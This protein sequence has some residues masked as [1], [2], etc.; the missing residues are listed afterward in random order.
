VQSSSSILVA[1]CGRASYCETGDPVGTAAGAS[2]DVVDTLDGNVGAKDGLEHLQLASAE[3]GAG[4]GGDAEGTGG[5]HGQ[6]DSPLLSLL[7]ALDHLGHV[8][9]AV[10]QCGER[11]ESVA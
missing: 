8:A 5:V 2:E 1:P 11:A 6:E 10:A 7:V 9:L 4:G 3:G